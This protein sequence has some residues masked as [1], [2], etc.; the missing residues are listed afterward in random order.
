[1]RLRFS[2]SALLSTAVVFAPLT[3]ISAQ[4]SGQKLSSPGGQAAPSQ[5]E[6][7]SS[8]AAADYLTQALIF[9]SDQVKVTFQAD[10][11]GTLE[12]TAVVRV[13]SPAGVQALAVLK[14]PY[15]SANQTVEVDYV[16]V[17][18][19]DGT[20]VT[21]PDY[22][23]QDMPAEL[24][25]DVPMYSDIHEKHVTVKALGVGDTLE[26]LVRYRTTKPQVPG[27]FWYEYNFPKEIASKDEELV[28]DVPRDK[29]VK[30]V[31]PDNPPQTKEEGARRI[32]TWKTQNLGPK[33]SKLP[34]QMQNQQNPP[35]SVQVTTFHSWEEVGNWYGGLQRSQVVVTPQ[36][37]A[38]AAELTKGLTSDDD[39]IR[40]L[41]DF[42]STQY[43]YVSLSFG[44][45]RYQPHA[46]EDVFENQYG[47]CKDKHTL[48]AALLK[49]AG[50]D[51]WPA[52][53]NS[54]RKLDPS[55]P[56]PAQFD[57]VITLVPRGATPLW[58]DTTPGVAPF[59]LLM[60][61]LRDKQAL[62]IPTNKPA[63]LMTT[64]ENPPFLSRQT[65][66]A[67]GKL[68]S[69]GTFTGHMTVSALGDAGVID[70]FVFQQYPS[71]Q[72]KD[73]VQQ[74]SYRWGYAGE[75]SGVNTSSTTEI[76]QPF[77]FSYD[78]KR[79]K[80]GD[81][82]NHRFT[83]PF[84]PTGLE[85]SVQEKKP[86]EPV[87]LGAPGTILYKAEIQLPAGYTATLPANADR[88]EDY[89]DYHASYEVKLGVLTVTRQLTIKK[90]QVPLSGW[91]AYQ[92]FA[93]AV[94][95]DRDTWI[96]LVPAGE[97]A[98]A[99]SSP[100]Q[101][102]ESSPE[103]D[104]LFRE[105]AEAMQRRDITRAEESFNRVL[106][107][108][109][110]YP[111]AHGNLGLVYLA[112]GNMD[113]GIRE[114]REEEKLNPDEPTA[115]ATLARV[116]AYKHD[117]AEATAQLQKLLEIDPKNRDAALSL[118]QLLT[119]EKK[120]PE[121]VAV[122]EKAY[123][124]APES[125]AVK[126]QLGFAYIRNGDKDKGLTL[127]QTALNAEQDTDHGAL[128]LNN[129]AYSL[130]DMNVGLDIAQRYA[131]K[132]LEQQSAESLKVGNGQDGITSTADLTATW[133][134]VGWIYFRRGD[135]EQALRYV[136][137]AW[138]SDQDAEVG[139]HL[140]QI[141]AKLGKK[142]EAAHIYRLA[143]A[144]AGEAPGMTS[145]SATKNVNL[146]QTIKQH[147]GELMG[148]DANP[149]TFTTSRRPD[150]SFT[151]MPVEELS[152]MRTVHF[153]T[154][155]HEPAAS[156]MVSIIFS[157]GKVE[158][159]TLVDGDESLKA[160]TDDIKKAK[161]DAEFPDA[162]PA[163]LVRRGVVACHGGSSCEVAL[164]PVEDRSLMAVE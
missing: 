40:A 14:F 120:Y 86:D 109:P 20:V 127:L 156:G 5:A 57:H 28:I 34:S 26:Y 123:Q 53:I 29:Y 61:N 67:D 74:I 151:P 146:A 44:I 98:V 17:R 80:I 18:K 21:T 158:E 89:A 62:V 135:Y 15:T 58:L 76:N 70:R 37:Q 51:A 139:D 46:A 125:G 108:S 133:D 8:A 90:A 95:D 121:A 153:T 11:S 138:L 81:W 41:Y 143:F 103:A 132:A 69:E 92:K 45:G 142:Q 12:R 22:N 54:T 130:I 112:T 35:P 16:R 60:V 24:T 144:A 33:A 148:K 145:S 106:E 118:G 85:A 31:S 50:Y 116:Y 49:A 96:Q 113:A 110:K 38:K 107:L 9:E 79:E 27:Q 115:Y 162:I 134:T 39:K 43:H 154:S 78:Y 163:R 55:V 161:F 87:F 152:R 136:K 75:V 126:Y 83:A 56:S 155:T 6:T 25:R 63:L 2:F 65:F 124:L 164:I 102:V 159:V 147:Y 59:G 91:D 141:Y 131:A 117:S 84:P 100:A 157:P 10:G 150:G 19:P 128:A 42:V 97:A 1:M 30:V 72:W 66:T 105:G 94:S 13:L 93:K 52:L 48:L 77:D 119:S 73:V 7:A 64:P 88:S 68:S 137:A 82:D 3:L 122:L 111:G 32:Y 71:S 36:I 4:S 23:T 140:G 99:A 129:V 104:R 149:G 101:P 114:L 160:L 47:D